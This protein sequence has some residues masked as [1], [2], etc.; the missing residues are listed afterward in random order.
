M[1]AA[2]CVADAACFFFLH[3]DV[4]TQYANRSSACGRQQPAGLHRMRISIEFHL[5]SEWRFWHELMARATQLRERYARAGGTFLAVT[6]LR[7][8]RQL[9]LS[10]YR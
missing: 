1:T 6:L 2:A 3:R 7:E 8:P 9:A 10:A 4:F 5:W